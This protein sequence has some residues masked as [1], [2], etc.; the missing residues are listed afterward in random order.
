MAAMANRLAQ[1]SSPYLLQHADNPVHWFPW[2]EEAFAKAR[3]EQKPIFL[4]VG[5]A[6]C[7][8]CHVMAHESFEDPAV[9][10]VL[11]ESFVSVKVDREERPDV[12][13]VYM[14]FVQAT[15]GQGGWPMSVW[16]TPDL[17][18]FYGGTYFPPEAR[19]G[20]PAFIDIL[21]RIAAA[22]RDERDQVVASA[23]SLTARLREATQAS[24]SAGDPAGLVIA[25]REALAEALAQYVQAYDRRHG[26]FGGA[27]KFPRPS[28][29]LF[30]LRHH[31]LTGDAIALEMTTETMRAMALGGMRDHVGGGFHRYAVDAQ[32]RV[33]HFEKMLYDQAQIVLALLE[34]AQADR[35]PFYASV[36]EDTL[37][38]V[39]RSLTSPEG[40][41]YSAE[42]ADSVPA[43][44]R[45]LAHPRT[46]EGAFYLWSLEEVESA[47]GPDLAPLVVARFGLRPGGNAHDPTGEFRGRNV[48]Y[49]ALDL[50]DVARETGR[51]LDEVIRGLRVARQRL[52]TARQE[53]PAPSLDDKVVTAGNGLM[54]AACARAGRVL[55]GQGAS[56]TEWLT[57]AERAAHFLRETLWDRDTNRLRRSWRAGQTGVDAFAEDYACV[58]WGALE[59]FQATGDSVWLEWAIDLQARLDEDFWDDTAGG[60]FST[61]G[62]D[63]SVLLRMK[64][65]YDGAEPSASSV[66][67]ANL[68]TLAH[69]TNDVAAFTRVER[70]LARGGLQLGRASRAVPFMLANLVAYHARIRQIVVV[71]HPGEDDTQALHQEIARRYLPFAVV[72]PVDAGAP[73]DALGR[74]LPFVA[75]LTMRDGRATAYVCEGFSCQ[76]PTTDPE[77]LGRQLDVLAGAR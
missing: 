39:R 44:E 18:P 64:E 51:P 48:L 62:D 1:A 31:A 72:V 34:V 69:L 27:P 2:G 75:P 71:G 8:W 30:L 7:H 76:A 24:A 42:D 66:A 58:T 12:D 21:R 37:A 74:L 15:T 13:R 47:V 10:A 54:I 77:E 53:R 28:E 23:S 68:L 55:T 16:L 61:A 40:G 73:R 38:Y 36:A 9:A 59:L 43:D 6:T 32:W 63:P 20:R 25:P 49:T 60:W 17:E 56:P 70:T 35:D 14:L 41:F 57:L 45:H 50:E 33:P 4:S 19:F 52:F 29:L 22:W 46:L 65:D 5:Y 67:V 11:N 3:A 26:G